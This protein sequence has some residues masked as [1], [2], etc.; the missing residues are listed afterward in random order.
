V[1]PYLMAF[2]CHYDEVVLIHL[3]GT[4]SPVPESLRLRRAGS[5]FAIYDVTKSNHCGK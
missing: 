1:F 5:F 3:G 4:R 2:Q